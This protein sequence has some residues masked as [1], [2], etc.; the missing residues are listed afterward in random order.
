MDSNLFLVSIFGFTAIML[1]LAFFARRGGDAD[2]FFAAGR[3]VGVLATAFSTAIGWMWADVFFS[4]SQ[5]G[6]DFGVFGLAWFAVCTLA[7]FVLFAALAN[8]ARQDAPLVTTIPE[9]VSFKTGYAPSAHI[10]M[11]LS[12]VLY[13]LFVLGLNATITGFLLHAAFG[14]DYLTSA[15]SI[16]LLVLTYS[17]I[18][19]LKTS[20]YTGIL[21]FLIVILLM[22]TIVGVIFTNDDIGTLHENAL[23][24]PDKEITSVF[25]NYLIVAL[26]IPLGIILVT[27]PLVDQMIFQRLIALKNSKQIMRTFALAGLLSGLGVLLFGYAGLSGLSLSQQGLIKVSDS[28]LI[29]VQTIGYYLSDAG[30][31]FFILAFFAVVFSTV[32]ACYC[33]LSAL[34]GYDVYKKYVNKDATDKELIKIGRLTMICAAVVGI[35]FS[36]AQFKILWMLFLVGV[37]GG[38]VVAP[39]IFAMTCKSISGRYIAISIVTSL[40]VALPLSI[41]GNV[42]GDSILVSVASIGSILIGAVICAFGVK[43]TKN[44]TFAFIIF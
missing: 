6:H 2:T 32:D 18:N 23:F 9:Y 24:G 34:I 20:T 4:T 14:F 33:A 16:V 22:G 25:N 12:I 27:Q 3:R 28:Q 37:I 39:V 35:L 36:L 17:L 10:A 11:T 44:L 43:K 7:S 38:S 42:H 26:V 13:Q 40:V 21:Q 15:S 5:I 31:F 8:R 30:L 19:G 1:G 41:Y 29:I